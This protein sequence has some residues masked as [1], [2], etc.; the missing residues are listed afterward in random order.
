MKQFIAK[1]DFRLASDSFNFVSIVVGKVISRLSF[2]ANL[3]AP[4]KKEVLITT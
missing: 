2:S 1:L 3:A 4:P